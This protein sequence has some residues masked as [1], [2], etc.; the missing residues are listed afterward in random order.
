MSKELEIL[1]KMIEK[2]EFTDKDFYWEIRNSY[3]KVEQALQR[4]E[5]IDNASPSE[6]LNELEMLHDCSTAMQE[7]PSSNWIE[8]AENEAELDL[9]LYFGYEHIKEALIKAQEMQ[10]DIIHYK[11]TID[12]LRRDN[13]LLKDIKNEQ[14]K[15]LDIAVK[16]G[17]DFDLLR[18]CNNEHEYNK[19]VCYSLQFMLTKEEFDLAKRYVDKEVKN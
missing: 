17:V 1:N 11:G 19:E 15:V 8:Y 4:L 12:N 3:A 16:K 2:V 9:K 10:E 7:L 18:T 5:A 13:A 14:E 6:A